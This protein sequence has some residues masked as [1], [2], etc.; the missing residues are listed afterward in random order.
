MS[1]ETRN[2]YVGPRTFEEQDANL[3]FGRERESRDLLSLV[4]TEPLVLF[5]AESGAG[6]SSIINTRLI[7]GLR[8]EQFNILPT[9]RVGG[10]LPDDL[11]DVPNIFV[12]NLLASLD[13]GKNTPQALAD[14]T[15]V[16]Y[17]R[18]FKVVAAEDHDTFY[19]ELGEES[20]RVLIIDQ[21]EEIVTTNLDRWQ[22]REG[23]FEQLSEAIREDQLLWVVLTLRED[24]VAALEPYARL[25][26]NRLR[27]RFYMQRM[28]AD[29]AE[30]AIE[31]PAALA[32]RPFAPGV[33]RQ[34]V[35]N[36]RQLHN[37]DGQDKT[38]GEYVEPVQLQVVCFQLWNNLEGRPL[39]PITAQDLEELGNV[40]QAL[41]EFY[42]HALA[43]ALQNTNVSEV[44]IRNW[45]ERHLITEANTRGTVYQG[46]KETAGM[47]NEVVL[48]LANQYL[49]RAEQRAGG[50]WYELV[51]D[52]FVEPILQ[53]NQTWRLKQSPLLRAAEE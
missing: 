2:P 12:F 38:L 51:H 8:E 22:D 32:G 40:D 1:S 15:I 48:L 33:A 43:G 50:M 18:M 30:Q 44:A 31:Q 28:K 5:Y 25:M 17:L 10:N 21:F 4:I 37:D 19:D 24:Y 53:A 46:A 16:E 52:R 23:F 14:L 9:G 42:E 35:D 47:P 49:L 45:F 13:K 34:L 36:L 29:A 6:K 26:P 39:G 20:A 41:G 11:E 27:A 3:F 7:P